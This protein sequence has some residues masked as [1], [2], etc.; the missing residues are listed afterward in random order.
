[1]I[2]RSREKM[3]SFAKPVVL[4]GVDHPIP[5]GE[6]RVK[7]DEELIEGISFPVYRRVATMIFV[8]SQTQRGAI[9]MV[10]IDPAVL[11]AALERDAAAGKVAA[12]EIA[13]QSPKA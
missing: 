1:M 2:A 10:T 7:T 4:E 6:Y 12:G 11:Q 5:A 9:E 8:P 13:A 3:V